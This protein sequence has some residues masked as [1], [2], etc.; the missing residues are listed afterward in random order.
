MIVDTGIDR[1]DEEGRLTLER[2]F[3]RGWQRGQS[4]CDYPLRME[5]PFGRGEDPV[6]SD[7]VSGDLGPVDQ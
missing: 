2:L 6:M 4:P 5:V 7:P 3:V 1:S